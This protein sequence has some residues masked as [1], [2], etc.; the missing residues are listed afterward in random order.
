MQ[1]ACA[2]SIQKWPNPLLCPH[3]SARRRR[4]HR[5][6]RPGQRLTGREAIQP[7]L[8]DGWEDEHRRRVRVG[9]RAVGA[10]EAGAA[11]GHALDEAAVLVECVCVWGGETRVM[12]FAMCA[13]KANVNQTKRT[14]SWR[15]SAR[16]VSW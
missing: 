7:V 12:C 5:R 6:A 1:C 3:T 10:V 2:D 15:P 11:G 14:A 13:R 4:H 9:E 8:V 16:A